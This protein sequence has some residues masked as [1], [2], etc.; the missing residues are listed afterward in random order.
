MGYGDHRR[1]GL[2]GQTL[3]H[4]RS[5]E[6][7]TCTETPPNHHT[8]R[9]GR[10]KRGVSRRHDDMILKKHGLKAKQRQTTTPRT[11]LFSSCPPFEPRTPCSQ[12]ECT[13][14]WATR[15]TQVGTTLD[16]GD[17]KQRCYGTH[18]ASVCRL[19]CMAV[20]IHVP[21]LSLC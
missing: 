12:G 11:T 18:S 21:F 1:L 7:S 17:L 16:K 10:R 2:E 6:M 15:A 19:Y 9:R 14:S 8:R 4:C 20:Y 3:A 13:T 5:P